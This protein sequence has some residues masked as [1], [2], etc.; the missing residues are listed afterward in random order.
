[1]P[2]EAGLPQWSGQADTTVGGRCRR[3]AGA[4]EVSSSASDWYLR[5]TE[6]CR[7]LPW[8]SKGRTPMQGESW[9]NGTG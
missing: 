5:S 7:P 3:R 2:W 4:S 1:G 8:K 6:R 9:P